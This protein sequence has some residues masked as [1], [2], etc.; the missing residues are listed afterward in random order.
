MI[1]HLGTYENYANALINFPAIENQMKHRFF[2]PDEIDD[3]GTKGGHVNK[4]CYLGRI[5]NSCLYLMQPTTKAAM[6]YSLNGI[7]SVL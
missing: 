7:T 2:S 5:I 3:Q 4:L 6:T 1:S